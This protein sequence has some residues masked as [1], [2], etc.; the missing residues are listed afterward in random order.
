MLT[1]ARLACVRG[2]RRLFSGLEF[3]LEAGGC[4]HVAG[5]NGAGKT[6]LLRTLCGL[7]PAEEGE[8]RWQGRPIGELGDEYR[9]AVLYFGHHNAL[10][11]ELTPLEN[12]RIAATLGGLTLDEETAFGLLQRAG[13][14]GREDLPVRVLSQGQ[15]RRAALARL[16]CSRA[17]LW[18]LDEPFVA[19]DV[20]AVSWLAGIIGA[21]LAG[22][23]CA[24]LTSHQEVAIPGSTVQTLRLS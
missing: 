16:L 6:S 23:G 15:K 3:S 24:V 21:H 20:A 13:L 11:E 12:L 18:I 1:V 17:P 14:R 5:E 8:I 9:Q 7:S 10:K 22:G 2:D 4:L 19:L